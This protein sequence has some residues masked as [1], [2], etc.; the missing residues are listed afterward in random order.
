MTWTGCQHPKTILDY[1][2]IIQ[3]YRGAIIGMVVASVLVT[4]VVSKWFL[5]KLY[6]A[7]ATILP[8]REEVFSG[9]ITFGGGKE[10]GGGGGG[11]G[12]GASSMM[13]QALGGNAGP[14]ITDIL[15]SILLSRGAA[16]A[17]VKELGLMAY[18]GTETLAEAVGAVRGEIKVVPNR[19][20]SIEITILTRDSQ[21]AASIANT[22]VS[23]LDRLHRELNLSSTKQHRLF[24]EKR[25]VEKTAQL[26]AADEAIRNF[27]TE[28][29]VIAVTEQA[30]AVT[31]VVSDL[32]G[33]I[34]EL[35]VELAALKQYAMPSHP[36]INQLQAQIQ[37]MR[38][39]LDRLER[40]SPPG[41]S[42]RRG[43]RPPM[44]KKAFAAIEEAPGLA[45]E[46]LR[47]T[48]RVKIEESVYGMLVGM[49]EQARIAEVRDLPTVQVLD[50]AVP[51]TRR[52]SPKTLNNVLAAAALS[53]LLGI[54]LA[55]FLNHLEV[56]RSQEDRSVRRS[57]QMADD[58]VV[59]SNGNGAKAR[60]YHVAPKP[61][62]RIEEG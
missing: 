33:K 21:M 44:S 57:D 8:A 50:L 13:M 19:Y 43:K 34:L 40:D 2:A 53:C 35:E 26:A 5:P 56:V 62:E 17:V 16:E 24:L 27:Q 12:N 47:L 18:Y 48:R 10:K 14:S 25:L 32:H 58:G 45:L 41:N 7:T 4:G 51:P 49:L 37:Q 54:L 28:N 6:E 3:H 30:E 39:Q 9:G 52:A 20:K 22:Y 15:Q 61:A 1:W 42:S 31:D 29:R 36:M 38:S 23:A 59:D 11:G 60:E 46:F 55:F